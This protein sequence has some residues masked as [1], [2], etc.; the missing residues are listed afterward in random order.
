MPR[1]GTVGPVRSAFLTPRWLAR[2]VLLVVT[3]VVLVRIGVWQWDKGGVQGSWQNYGY[4][5]QWWL[6]AAFAVFLYVKAI[7]D[8]LDPSRLDEPEP[9]KSPVPPPAPPTPVQAAPSG[10]PDEE[11]E[12]LAAYNRHL[13]WLAEKA[14]R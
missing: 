5:L 12:E 1:P 8:E 10:E 2:H 13:A 4:G 14:K 3:V 6:F 9:R 7:L 11:D